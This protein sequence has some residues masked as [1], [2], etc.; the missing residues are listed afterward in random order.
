MS[1]GFIIFGGLF[2]LTAA[3]LTLA[4]GAGLLAAFAAYSVLGS[5]GLLLMAL[6]WARA[7]LAAEGSA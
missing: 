2:G 6:Q 5:A 1:I 4:A 7:E 3:V